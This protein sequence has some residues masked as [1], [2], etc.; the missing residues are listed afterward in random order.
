[1]AS[2]THDGATAERHLE[3]RGTRDREMLR[4]FLDQDRLFAAYAVADLDPSEFE[5]TRWGIAFD[6]RAPV[7]V[8]LEYRGI[9]PQPLFAMGDPAGVAAILGDVI[10]P[11]VAYLGSK[12]DVVPAVRQHYRVEAA[13]PMVRMAVDRKAFRPVVGDAVRLDQADARHLNRLYELGLTSYLPEGAVAAGIYYGVRRGTR[14]IAAAGTHVI[15]PTYGLAAVGNVYTSREH[16]GEGLAK[17]VTSAVTAELFRT[18]DTVVLNVRA[19]NPPA[20]AVYRSLGYREHTQFE[21]RL[22]H[23]Q[24]SLWD[25]IFGPVRAF[26]SDLRRNG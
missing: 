11:R 15:S 5:R 2:V 17:V 19:D 4:Q 7:S 18:V 14:L 9:S 8:V 10:R 20:L 22:V 25:S 21:E 13:A 3:V 1:M 26:V 24:T 6:D 16:R 23:R 12:P